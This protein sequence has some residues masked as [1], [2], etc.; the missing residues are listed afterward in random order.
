MA[1]TML[2]IWFVGT[3]L[4]LVTIYLML[5]YWYAPEE[6]GSLEPESAEPQDG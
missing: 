6:E 4:S 2:T 3:V 5:R 1:M